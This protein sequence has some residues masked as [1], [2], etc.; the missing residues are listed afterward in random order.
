MA[1][2]EAG[3]NDLEAVVA[4]LVGLDLETP[5]EADEGVWASILSQSGRTVLIAEEDDAVVG[6]LDLTIVPNL[7]REARPFAIA[8]NI[9]VALDSRGSGVGRAL[10]EEAVWRSQEAGCYKIQLMSNKRRTEAHDFY[11]SCGFEAQAEGFRRY[12]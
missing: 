4:L 3:P 10:L 1:I 6:T 11:R 2:R 9:A 12:F 8:E 7:T 5:P